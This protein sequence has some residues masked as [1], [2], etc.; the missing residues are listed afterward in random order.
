MA[1][2][3]LRAFSASNPM[4]PSS[5][6]MKGII[7]FRARHRAGWRQVSYGRRSQLPPGELIQAMQGSGEAAANGH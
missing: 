6:K 7:D 5:P 4:A 1:G 2:A 3:K